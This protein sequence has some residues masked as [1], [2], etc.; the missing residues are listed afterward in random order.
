LD[1]PSGVDNDLAYRK[2]RK[3][4]GGV[5]PGDHCFGTQQ[6]FKKK[7]RTLHQ[8]VEPGG[9]GGRNGS[10]VTGCEKICLDSTLIGKT[11]GILS[12]RRHFA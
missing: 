2:E 9:G 1:T 4:A 10:L 3:A 6:V 11:W 5:I 7:S 12:E 8:T